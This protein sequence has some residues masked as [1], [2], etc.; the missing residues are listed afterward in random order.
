ME[1]GSIRP[2]GSLMARVMYVKGSGGRTFQNSQEE[3][4]GQKDGHE[5]WEVPGVYVRKT[6]V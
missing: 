5:R 4:V 3:D 6:V 1:G 2:A